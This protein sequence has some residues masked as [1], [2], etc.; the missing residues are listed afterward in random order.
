MPYSAMASFLLSFLKKGTSVS[1]TGV[2]DANLSLT[3]SSR[4]S[5]SLNRCRVTR[6]E[7]TALITIS[8]SSR[9]FSDFLFLFYFLEVGFRLSSFVD[10]DEFVMASYR[11][12]SKA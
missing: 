7:D 11:S 12:L 1:N 10:N 2:F 3:F 9:S 6:F 4:S 8:S 5:S